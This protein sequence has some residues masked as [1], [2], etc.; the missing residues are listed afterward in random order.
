MV[1]FKAHQNT[2]MSS[3]D[4]DAIQVSVVYMRKLLSV[5]TNPALDLVVSKPKLVARMCDLI[6]TG[7]S[8]A[9]QF[10]AAWAVTNIASGSST[11]CAAAMAHGAH[12]KFLQVLANS[13][14]MEQVGSRVV[15]AGSG[16]WLRG[17]LGD[18]DLPE[19]SD[20][21]GNLGAF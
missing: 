9:I 10:E 21:L 11:H 8:S 19:F 13:S 2:I 17:S 1:D 15:A 14:S 16:W 12:T 5:E 20:S 4:D 3:S 7:G 18:L 6:L